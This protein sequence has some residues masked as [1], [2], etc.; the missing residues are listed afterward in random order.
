MDRRA[1]GGGINTYRG[2]RE[3][4]AEGQAARR[5]GSRPFRAQTHFETDARPLQRGQ[6]QDPLDP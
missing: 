3:T 6:H 4:G 5:I 1:R 2:D